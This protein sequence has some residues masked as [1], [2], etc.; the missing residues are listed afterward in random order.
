MTTL[1]EPFYQPDILDGILLPGDTW[2]PYPKAAERQNWESLPRSVS[3]SI[4][5]EG[6][7]AQD[8]PWPHLPA[9]LYLEYLVNG[10]R[11][12]FESSY[13]LRR[14]ILISLVL[15]ECMDGRG[16]FIGVVADAVWSICEESTWCL[17][18]HINAQTA[19]VE[20]PDTLEPIVDLFAAETG[21]LLSWTMYLLDSQ[22]SRVSTMIVPRMQREIQQRILAPCLT[23][24]DFWWMGFGD[25]VVNNWNPWINSNWLSCVLLVEK[26]KQRHL[27]A[28]AKILRSL[29]KFL[30]PYPEDGGCDEGPSYWGVAGASL[31][32][33][34]SMLLSTTNGKLDIF[35]QPLVQNIGKYIYRVHIGGN[36]YINFADASAVLTP[37]PMLVYR[38]GQSIQDPAMQAFGAWLFRQSTSREKNIR[39]YPRSSR[40]LWR[41][42]ATLF[43]M[44]EVGDSPAYPPYIKDVWLPGLQVIAA[45]EQAGSE[46]GFF[47]A[48][49]GGHNDESH[50]HNDVGHF[51]VYRD[52]LPLLVDVGV[53]TY[54]RK[55][56]SPERYEIWTMQSSYHALPTIG[57]TMQQNGREFSARNVTAFFDNQ[58]AVFSLDIAP[59]YPQTAHLNRWQRTITLKTGAG[60]QISDEFHLSELTQPITLNL[61]TPSKPSQGS[62]GKIELSSCKLVDD[63]F[64]A[65]GVITYDPH[66]LDGTFEEIPIEDIRLKGSWGNRLWRLIFRVKTVSLS[67]KIELA[68][69][70]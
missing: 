49:K 3:K 69:H 51:I 18:A 42:L 68:I 34:L 54:T 14:E 28:M 33:G 46:H 62:Y 35:K 22:L 38:Y 16:R 70:H 2:H 64:S 12:N 67:G 29:D 19:G 52:G 21:A 9:S 50:N 45:R 23:R 63:R 58:S 15:A 40:N 27:D 47:L 48:A 4:L 41:I 43:G 25:R 55:T 65:S 11:S 31:Y 5:E 7:S 36:Y 66:Q 44:M 26:D 6:E 53:E 13:F 56:F 59:A 39:S 24:D 17:P 8:T 60:V 61:I 37:D 57:G 30:D 20:L 32:D 10:N 1:L